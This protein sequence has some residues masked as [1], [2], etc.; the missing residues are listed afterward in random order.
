ML[1]AS[2]AE[3]RALWSMYVGFRH[4]HTCRHACTHTCNRMLCPAYIDVNQW[5]LW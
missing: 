3:L 2:P 4:M 5:K 1:Q